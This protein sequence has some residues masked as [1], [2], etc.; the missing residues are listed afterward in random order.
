M[1]PTMYHHMSALLWLTGSCPQVQWR[2]FE[3]AGVL[4]E[5]EPGGAGLEERDLTPGV[6]LH[7]GL[8]RLWVQ[9]GT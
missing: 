6:P 2:H 8:L 1:R 7:Q 9:V 5:A 4:R 3:P